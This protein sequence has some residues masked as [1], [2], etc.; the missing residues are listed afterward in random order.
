M[1]VTQVKASKPG[2]GT[3]APVSD[4]HRRTTQSSAFGPLTLLEDGEFYSTLQ[5]LGFGNSSGS[6]GS[7]GKEV[8]LAVK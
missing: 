6:Q 7:A 8:L 1:F 4:P 5:L 2:E 3:K